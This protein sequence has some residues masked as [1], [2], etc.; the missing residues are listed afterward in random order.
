MAY[1]EE[2]KKRRPEIVMLSDP[3]YVK[4]L[5][6]KRSPDA[7]EYRLR[8]IYHELIARFDQKDLNAECGDCTRPARF[9]AF[10]KG[11]FFREL[12]CGEC[13]PFWFEHFQGRMDIFSSYVSALDYVYVY[14]YGNRFFF[15]SVIREIARLKGLPDRA[16]AKDMINFF[17]PGTN[18]S[19]KE[20]RKNP[21][22]FTKSLK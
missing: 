12:W 5:L 8:K 1:N 20:P 17:H 21:A 16:R 15:R 10:Y 19:G 18:N 3:H 7:E 13:T 9:L 11:T 4:C 6:S 2:P 22:A 14:L